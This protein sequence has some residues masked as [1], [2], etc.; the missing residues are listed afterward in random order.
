[1]TKS[2]KRAIIE[3]NN[4]DKNKKFIGNTNCI[5]TF[6]SWLK[7]RYKSCICLNAQEYSALEFSENNYLVVHENK[8]E[9]V[10][11]KRTVSS[12]YIFNSLLDTTECIKYWEFIDA[13]NFY[14]DRMIYELSVDADLDKLIV[15]DDACFCYEKCICINTSSRQ[16]NLIFLEKLITSKSGGEELQNNQFVFFT[17][18]LNYYQSHYPNLNVTPI[19]DYENKICNLHGLDKTVIIFENLDIDSLGVNSL[20]HLLSDTFCVI[21]LYYDNF[22]FNMMRKQNYKL[23]D[24]VVFQNFKSLANQIKLYNEIHGSYY[25]ANHTEFT[26]FLTRAI[27][28]NSKYFISYKYSDDFFENN[29]VYDCDRDCDCNCDIFQQKN[30]GDFLIIS[31]INEILLAPLPTLEHSLKNII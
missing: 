9:L 25:F 30:I 5:N 28:T 29:F 11:K 1:M 15:I 7:G 20:Y 21:L 6:V 8:I 16:S 4:V 23:I 19:D 14:N 2:V 13:D 24:M 18:D 26:M 3:N 27:N 22:F 12:G 17:D 10:I 31:D